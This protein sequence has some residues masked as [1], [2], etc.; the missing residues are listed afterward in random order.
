V[1]RH[2]DPGGPAGSNRQH[3]PDRRTWPVVLFIACA[4]AALVL[5]AGGIPSSRQPKSAA[6]AVATRPLTTT[7][8]AYGAHA[9]DSSD[10]TRAIQAAVNACR[11]GGGT[12]RFP[13][14]TYLVSK[15]I[16]LP[17]GNTAVLKLS[18]Y[19]A[20]I[21]L[22]HTTPR[23]LV[24][25]TK[26]TTGLTFRHFLVQG[27][28]VDAQ[29]HHPASGEWS[30]V[31]FDCTSGYTTATN[32]DD[33]TVR[34]V[35][36]VNVPT[37]DN[38]QSYKAFN[39][40]VYTSGTAHIS[41]VLVQRCHLDGGTAGVSVWGAGATSNVAIRRVSILDCWHDTG[42]QFTQGGDSENYHVGSYGH[43]GSASVV[44]CTG[45]N[46]GDVGVEMNN[47]SE[48]LVANCTINN[49]S[50]EA[51]Y[52]TNYSAP[53]RGAGSL[54]WKNDVA[55]VAVQNTA[56]TGQWGFAV[57]GAGLP[58]G[59]VDLSDC[60]YNLTA[61]GPEHRA[62]FV[63]SSASMIAL[64][65]NGLTV[66]NATNLPDSSMVLVEPSRGVVTITN[67]TVNGTSLY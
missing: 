20:R 51:F 36:T 40:N 63:A 23:F 54:T 53:L 39:I 44:N 28:T 41:D 56:G 34:D 60:S 38:P 5:T 48:G 46:S 25:N 55:N 1:T 21:K 16:K 9:D 7:V 35:R 62:L 31:G 67:V 33:V 47:T 26:G 27:F 59:T 14:G 13:A 15:P 49:P 64:D 57:A 22:S 19:G 4:A 2:D 6:A 12:V 24:W 45:Y 18:G 30:V 61:Q 3:A 52:Y 29:G 50:W 58:I 17:A 65:V 37:M 43:V 32:I 11:A 10:D 8:T 42:I 66:T